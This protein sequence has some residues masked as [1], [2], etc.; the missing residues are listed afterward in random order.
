MTE[1]VCLC[2][3]C[4]EPLAVSLSDQPAPAANVPA[5]RALDCLRCHA[6][7]QA[8]KRLRLHEGSQMLPFLLDQFGELLVNR[9]SFDTYACPACGKV[10]FFLAG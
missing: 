2:G 8:G 5:A 3:G 4:G 10:E 6:P 1:P 9:E 7:M